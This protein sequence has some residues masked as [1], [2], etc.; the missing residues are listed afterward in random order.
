[1]LLLPRSRCYL[2][3]VLL[4]AS[5]VGCKRFETWWTGTAPDESALLAQVGSRELR[6]S[7]VSNLIP[8]GTAAVDSLRILQDYVHRWAREMS[9]LNQAATHIGAE[10]DLEKL[11]ETYRASLQRHRLE[12]RLVKERV[13]TVVSQEELLRRY[14]AMADSYR[15]PH[16]L[17]RALLIKVSRASDSLDYFDEA[18]RQSSGEEVSVELERLAATEAQLALLDGESWHES[19]ELQSLLPPDWGDISRGSRVSSDDSSRY[20][21]RILERVSR[22]N[23]CPLAYLEPRLRKLI[24]EERRTAFLNDYVDQVYRDAQANQEIQILSV[25]ANMSWLSL[26]GQ[27]LMLTVL[28]GSSAGAAQA[29][30]PG[31]IDHVIATVG[32]ELLLL[33]ELEEQLS[34]ARSQSGAK[35]PPDARCQILEQLLTAKLLVNQAKLDSL[36][37]TDDQVESQ[38][39]L[40]FDRILSMMNG[41]VQQFEEYYGQT[42]TEVKSQ[43]RDDLKSQMLADEMRRKVVAEARIT[44]NEVKEFFETIPKDSLPYFN[45]EVEL[46]ELVYKPKIN[47]QARQAALDQINEIRKALVEE[48]ADFATIARKQSADPGSGRQGGQLGWAPR[49]TFVPEFEAAAYRLEIDELSEVVESPFGFHLIQ[50]LERRGNRVRTRHILIKPAIEEADLRL[51]EQFLDSVRLLIV[52]DSLLFR[53]AVKRFGDDEEQSYANGG[54][55]ENPATGNTFYEIGDLEPV[56]FFAIDSMAVG[57][58]SG[59]VKYEQ[60]GTGEVVY[61]IFQ[62]DSRSKPHRASLT[63]DYDKIRSAAIESRKSEI[64]GEWLERTIS[65][66]YININAQLVSS[67]KLRDRWLKSSVV[68]RS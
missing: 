35:M 68:D 8:P 59:P 66:T 55:L 33:S 44:P 4:S 24:L 31:V 14:Q 62:L 23:R 5:L 13:D 53:E 49:G 63:T 29:Q 60:P 47:A 57:E 15:A 2:L 52:E 19:A 54:R 9:V 10:P 34:L 65:N 46:R 39:N 43:F 26:L 37:V 21:L 48:G 22:G 1:M 38:L 7:E 64:L 32:G 41:D 11:V 18:W 3:V 45:S 40:R 36:E 27:L 28:C 12:E 61:R 25:E 42:V 20:Y 30:G 67:C 6:A 58:V 17:V 51:A 56:T 16:D 50:L